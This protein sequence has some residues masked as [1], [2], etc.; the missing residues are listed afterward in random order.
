MVEP[1]IVEREP[2]SVTGLQVHYDGDESIFRPLWDEFGARVDAIEGL[3]AAEEAFGVVTDYD[4]E[5]VEFDY[6][7]GLEAAAFDL[8]DDGFVTVDVP[9]GTFARFETSLA[10]FQA[11]YG[12]VTE[13]WLPR[14][15]YDRRAVPEFEV[16]GPEFNPEDDDPS[17]EY[18]LPVERSD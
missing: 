9:G 15:R 18:F 8:D 17:Y 1:T 11:D 5:T 12:T 2:V 10:S 13:E 3:A 14:S 7:V 4:A 6:L 16:Y